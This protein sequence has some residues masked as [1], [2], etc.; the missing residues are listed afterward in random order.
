MNKRKC[1]CIYATARNSAAVRSGHEMSGYLLV[2]CEACAK[3]R[4]KA[5]GRERC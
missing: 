3:A 4:A 1:K 5:A 2:E